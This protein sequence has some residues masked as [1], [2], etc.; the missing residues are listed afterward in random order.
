MSDSKDSMVTYT[1]V[2]SPFRGLSDI[3]S[4]K[5][6]GSPVMPEDPY[7][8]VVVAFQAPPSLDY[9]PGPEYPPLPEFIPEPVNPEYMPSEDEILPAEEQPLPAAVSPT[10]DSPGYVLEFDFE[11]DPEED[12]ADYPIA[13]LMAIPTPPPSPLSPLLSP[14]PPILSPLPVSPLPLP[15]PLPMSLTY[16]LGYQATM[17]QLRADAPSTSHPLLLPSTYHL[18]PPSGT[19]P[20]L[21]IPLS[22]PS[23]PLLPPSTDPRADIREVCLP[24]QKRLCYTCGLRFKVGGSIALRD[25]GVASSRPTEKKM[26]DYYCP[27][28]KMKKLEFEL[29]NL[30]VKGTDVIGYNQR[31]QDLALLCVRMFLEEF[32]KIKRYVSGLPYMIHKSIVA[33]K[34]KTLQEAVEM[35]TELMDKKIRTFA[36]RQTE[37]KR[38]QDNVMSDSKDSMV[39]YTA[40]SSPF[41]GLSDI[42]SLKV[43]GSPVM[44]EDPYAYV[45]VTFQAP[46]S[47]DYV[48]G[49]EYPPLPEFIPEP[50]NPEY[51]PSENEILPAEEQPLP[52]AVSPTV[53]SPGYVLEFDFEEDPEEDPADYPVDGGY[54]GD[55]EDESSDDEE[56]DDVEEDEDEEEEKEHLAPADSIVFALPALRADAPSTSHPLLLPSTYHLIPPSGTPPLLPIPLSTPS[57]P[58]L[59]PSTDPRADIREVCL[60]PQKRLCYTCGLR[61]EVGGSIALRDRGVASSRP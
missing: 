50:V 11:E 54:D 42:V 4:P 39:T 19:P 7:A 5:V 32:D 15:L 21:P 52:A 17:I 24:P 37:T 58:L 18:T 47:L 2:S 49:P 31:F 61:F 60:P 48:S 30:K 16:P 35:A 55:D 29:W 34:P 57:P 28:V 25:R 13:K 26:T 1:A 23:P 44:P 33:S 59:P 20:L 22:T 12:P 8:Y 40:V 43:D 9:V 53:D 41:R 46:P 36:E 45:V 10:V 56:D 51:M 3:V 6:D 38:K 14:L 27:M